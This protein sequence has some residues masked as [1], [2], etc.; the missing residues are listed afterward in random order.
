MLNDYPFIREVR[1]PITEKQLL[2]L[3]P[4]CKVVQFNSPLTD[5]DFMRLARFLE[6][7]P[8]IPLRI[9][10]HYGQ[11]PDLS[12]LRYFPF[13]LG[14]Q[15]DVYQLKDINGLES[16]PDNLEFLGLGQTKSRMSLRSLARFK[17]LKDL[18]LEGH[19]KDFSAI[20]E[21]K[22]LIYLSLRSISLPDLSALIPLRRLRS[23]ALKLGGTK[24][25]S[26][27]PNI[28]ELRYL[29]LW[30]V[31]GLADLTPI[32]QLREL[33]YLFL[34]DLKQVTQ[35]PS[36]RLLN[37]LKRCHIESLKGLKDLC[38]IAEAINLRELVVVSM[39]QIPVTG[40]ECFRN[41][42]TLQ[43]ASIGLGSLRRN[44]EVSKLLGLPTPPAYDKPIKRFVEDE[45]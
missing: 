25:L 42:P 11:T 14:F 4:Q 36:F 22:N 33:R 20:S 17:N 13:L 9:Y 45:I 39:K 15:A 38:P 2:P 12:F 7:Y 19:T 5:N 37:N 16:L 21:L 3:D 10:G 6:A 1:S 34:Q 41:H 30:M 31:K 27:L 23:L 44:A 35:L 8:G 28:S 29:E 43:E 32:G 26:L 18:F 40:F 24:E